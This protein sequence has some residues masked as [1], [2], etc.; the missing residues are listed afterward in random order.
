MECY[1]LEIPKE[2]IPYCGDMLRYDNAYRVEKAEEVLRV[3][4]TNY[5]P[6]RWESFGI[7]PN[8]M[9][10]DVSKA[11]YE[12]FCQQGYGFTEGFRCARR[13]PELEMQ[14]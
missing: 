3:Y 13:F 6:K 11:E 14:M 10:L 2:Q 7:R 5:T 1:I 9:A 12:R 4:T 8:V